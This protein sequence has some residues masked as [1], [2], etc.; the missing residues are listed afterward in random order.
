IAAR[1]GCKI[2]SVQRN[3]QLYF[4]KVPAGDEKTSL[5]KLRSVCLK[6]QATGQERRGN[7]AGAA[8]TRGKLPPGKSGAAGQG[9]AQGARQGG[10]ADQGGA[11]DPGGEDKQ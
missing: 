6:G 1:I 3:S 7:V 2:V 5:D 11:A 8:R 4:G 9:A 10:G